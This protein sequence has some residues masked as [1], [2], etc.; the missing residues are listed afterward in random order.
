MHIQWFPGHMTRAMR[1]MEE[2]VK[3]CDGIVFVL[4]ARAPYACLNDNLFKIFGTRPVVYV[5][6]KYDLVN[7]SEFSK[8]LEQFK[9]QNKRAVTCV[10]TSEKCAKTIYLEIVNALSSVLE[11]YKNKGIKRPLRIMVAGLPNTGKSTIINLL[12]G[13]KK[14]K[15]GDK[16]GVTKD[17]QW[18]KVQNLELLD[19]PG[20][21]PPSFDSEK[22]ATF[23]AFIGSINDDILDFN[24]L[25]LELIAYLIKNYQNALKQAYGIETDGKTEYQIFEEIAKIKGCLKKGGVIDEERASNLIFSDL[26]KGKLGKILFV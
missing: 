10:G 8:V 5:F 12:C 1:M 17:K 15:T 6:N 13:G 4:D 23:L 19:T 21:T 24:E 20:T 22:N 9:A 3:L 18:L 14:A 7:Q 16:A 11:K 25:S 2:Q 26:R